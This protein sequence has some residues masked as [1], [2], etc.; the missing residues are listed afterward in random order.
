MDKYAGG[1]FTCL[2]YSLNIKKYHTSYEVQNTL[3]VNVSTSYEP[4]EFFSCLIIP[5]FFLKKN[6]SKIYDQEGSTEVV[7][8]GSQGLG[9]V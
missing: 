6:Y 4:R 7:R 8:I 1:L 9:V 5:I 2:N 3:H